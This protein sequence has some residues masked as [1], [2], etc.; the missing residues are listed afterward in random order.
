[1]VTTEFSEQFFAL[2]S[3]LDHQYK[4]RIKKLIRKLVENPEIGKPMRYERKGT[5]E[6]YLPPFRLVYAWLPTEDKIIL[7]DIYHKDKQ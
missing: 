2:Y 4:A 5:R 6:L 7:L 1:M 3:R